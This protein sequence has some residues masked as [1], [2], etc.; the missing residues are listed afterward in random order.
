MTEQRKGNIE[1]QLRL[2]DFHERPS[3]WLTLEIWR[4]KKKNKQTRYHFWRVLF[5]INPH[6]GC[7]R[8]HQTWHDIFRIGDPELELHLWQLH[9]GWGCRSKLYWHKRPFATNL[10]LA[11]FEKS[12]IWCLFLSH[13]TRQPR[14]KGLTIVWCFSEKQV[15]M[16]PP[17]WI[18]KTRMAPVFF[19]LQVYAATWPWPMQISRFQTVEG[20]I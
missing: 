15:I 11:R 7:N 1:L 9:P 5:W 10:G 8:Q 19:M 17:V 6:P 2:H 13:W 3:N 14:S 20:W 16:P 18:G 4:K 12:K